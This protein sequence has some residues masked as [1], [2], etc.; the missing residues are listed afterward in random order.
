MSIPVTCPNGHRMNLPDQQGGK[1]YRCP[2]CFMFVDVP[3]PGTTSP[4]QEASANS[5]PQAAPPVPAPAPAPIAEA[6]AAPPANAAVLNVPLTSSAPAPDLT[7]GPPPTLGEKPAPSPQPEFV[8]VDWG[9]GLHYFRLPV[10]LL[11][12]LVGLALAVL[13]DFLDA[14]FLTYAGFMVTLGSLLVAPLLGAVGS[15]LCLKFPRDA[16][17]RPLLRGSLAF[18]LLAIVMGV[19][20]IVGAFGKGGSVFAQI[21]GGAFELVAWMIFMVFMDQASRYLGQE[22]ASFEALGLLK[23][24]IVLTVVWGLIGA[25]VLALAADL[26]LL[27]YVV[28][29]PLAVYLLVVTFFF[30]IQVLALVGTIRQVIR[31]NE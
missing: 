10:F 31:F 18:D 29:V 19:L 24:G 25:A 4:P 5:S 6:P 15:G 14:R 27:V 22:V 16:K 30:L 12:V 9:L 21:V 23:K 8:W 1:R 2:L 7:A 13:K 26:G 17:V 11:S 28:A 3:L 20:V